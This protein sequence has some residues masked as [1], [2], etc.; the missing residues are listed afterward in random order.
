MTEASGDRVAAALRGFGPLG[1]FA[2]LI[3]VAG[4]FVAG[5]LGNDAGAI[6]AAALARQEVRQRAANRAGSGRGSPMTS[7]E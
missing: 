6:G 5:T 3:I 1:L 7:H 2:I 4:S